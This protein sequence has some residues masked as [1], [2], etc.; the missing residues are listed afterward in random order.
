MTEPHT[1]PPAA[2]EKAAAGSRNTLARGSIL[3]VIFCALVLAWP[4][5]SNRAPAPD[6]QMEAFVAADPELV[7]IGGSSAPVVTSDDVTPRFYSISDMATPA[8]IR[9]AVTPLFD[10]KQP[11]HVWLF[12][13]KAWAD[14]SHSTDLAALLDDLK[15]RGIATTLI[16]PP[17]NDE[18][19]DETIDAL[20]RL[21]NDKGITFIDYHDAAKLGAAL[22]PA[23]ESENENESAA[24]TV[25]LENTVETYRTQQ[26]LLGMAI[27]APDLRPQLRLADIGAR[28]ERLKAETVCPGSEATSAAEATAEGEAVDD[29]AVVPSEPAVGE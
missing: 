3:L 19:A 28:I 23:N 21:S 6:Q 13:D 4:F 15:T 5:L 16:L 12:A 27:S 7:A 1:P 14:G 8:E 26:M 2:E 9:M 25:A 22:C 10:K 29:T 17:Q 24:D 11:Q 18:T 20:A